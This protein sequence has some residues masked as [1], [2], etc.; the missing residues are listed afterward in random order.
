VIIGEDLGT[1]PE[2]FQ[3][4]LAEAGVLG[5]RVLW[6][7][8]EHGLFRDPSRWPADVVATTST[9]DLPTVA[10]WWKER[11]IDW[12]LRVAQ[13]P[14]DAE[15]QERS[16]RADERRA[17]W[18]ACNHASIT[19]GEPPP[20]EAPAPAIDAALRFVGRTPSR[21]AMIPLEDFVGL[22]EQPNL[23]GTVDEHPNWRRRMPQTVEQ[24]FETPEV[25]SR[26]ERLK[27]ERGR[28]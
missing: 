9:H 3:D 17:L 7:E 23:P 10:G 14:H 19:E 20:R 11:D 6:F 15:A 25:V 22:D 27:S 13:L 26:L 1:V 18:A 8:R 5:M 12:R 2:G 24:L 4:T 16:R 21:L 28:P